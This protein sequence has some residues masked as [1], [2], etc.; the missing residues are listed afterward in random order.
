MDGSVETFMTTTSYIIKKS[1]LLYKNILVECCKS[2]NNIIFKIC[3]KF[4]LQKK[5]FILTMWK[6]A[7]LTTLVRFN[8][9][10]SLLIA[11]L[12]TTLQNLKKETNINL[13]L[14]KNIYNMHN[15]WCDT[16]VILR[17]ICCNIHT[18]TYVTS[19]TQPWNYWRIN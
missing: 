12:V 1:L 18:H 6:L 17:L 10:F 19:I 11:N 8:H 5:L 13:S 7:L 15:F 16:E 3:I 2:W 4:W 14:Y 9:I